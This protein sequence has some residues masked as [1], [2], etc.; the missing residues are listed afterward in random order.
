M[1]AILACDEEGGIG[2]NGAMPWP[3]L[4]SDLARFKKLTIGGTVIMGR[5]AWESNGMPKPLPNR[6]NVVVSKKELPSLPVGVQQVM[7]TGSIQS[8][9]DAWIIGGAGLFNSVLDQIDKVYLTRVPGIYRCD[10]KIDLLQLEDNFT[11]LSEE[12]SIGH[13]LQIW[14][15]NDR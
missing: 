8:W 12:V 9:P 13:L 11:L 6:T 15:K 1:K 7:H 2:L 14:G 10:T 5:G 3:H 4:A